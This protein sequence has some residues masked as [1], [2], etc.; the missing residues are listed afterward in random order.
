MRITAKHRK[1]PE[2][3]AVIQVAQ[4]RKEVVVASGVY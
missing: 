2:Q 4:N 3:D 1:L